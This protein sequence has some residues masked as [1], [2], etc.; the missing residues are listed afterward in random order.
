MRSPVIVVTG[1]IASGKSLIA[2]VMAERGGALVDCDGLA[3]RAYD[4]S[5]LVRKVAGAFGEGVLTRNGRVS[6]VRLGRVV[7]EDGAALD[8]LNLLVRPFVKRIISNEVKR[9]QDGSGYIVLDA[10]LFFQYTFRFKADLIVLADAPER[11]R[12]GRIV[13]RDGV[14]REEAGLRIA[15]QRPLYADWASI[16]TVVR[17][18]RPRRRVIAETRAIRDRFLERYRGSRR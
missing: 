13:R 7:F 1:G 11:I 18:D 8:C 3:R 4:D 10:V 6:R 5:V 2:R 15:R 14:S 12:L 16:D 17:T 9:L